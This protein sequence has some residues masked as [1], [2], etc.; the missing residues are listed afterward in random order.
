VGL[1]DRTRELSVLTGLIEGAQAGNSA[2]MVLRGEPGIGKTALL[3]AVSGSADAQGMTTA[4]VT[5]IE[6]EAP[7]GYEAGGSV[8]GADGAGN[9][10][11]QAGRRGRH[12]P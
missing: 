6:S 7:L 9:P 1:I 2:A 3:E 11:R 12:Q 4:V 10:G 8:L 5:G